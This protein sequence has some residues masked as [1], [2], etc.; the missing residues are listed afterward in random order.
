M[1]FA[2]NRI[3]SVRTYYEDDG[4]EGTVVIV[5]GGLMQSIVEPSPEDHRRVLAVVEYLTPDSNC[6]SRAAVPAP[7]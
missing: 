2:S 1:R 7:N 4:G 3:D 5:Y 6:A